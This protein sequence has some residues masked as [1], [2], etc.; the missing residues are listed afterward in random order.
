[1]YKQFIG[2]LTLIG[3]MDG[4]FIALSFLDWILP[5]EFF[6][7]F[8]KVFADENWY[9]SGWFNTLQWVL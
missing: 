3:M 7:K 2:K 8:P 9:Q 1:M 5:A 6:Q 4:T